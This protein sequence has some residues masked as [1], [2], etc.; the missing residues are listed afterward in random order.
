MFELAVIGKLDILGSFCFN[1]K[2][3]L[4]QKESNGIKTLG[5]KSKAK[6]GKRPFTEIGGRM[7]FAIGTTTSKKWPD[8][9][10]V[11]SYYFSLAGFVVCLFPSSLLP[12]L[13]LYLL[14]KIFHPAVNLD[15]HVRDV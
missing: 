7:R 9:S 14:G 11:L 8:Q 15:F 12:F 4:S 1:F 3:H 5:Q 10:L 2:C 13:S 6:I